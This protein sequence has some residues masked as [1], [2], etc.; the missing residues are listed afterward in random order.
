[1]KVRAEERDTVL[2]ND[3]HSVGEKVRREIKKRK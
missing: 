1:M 3:G 2:G